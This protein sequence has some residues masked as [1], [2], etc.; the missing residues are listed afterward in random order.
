M[1]KKGYIILISIIIF[2]ILLGIGIFGIE[3]YKE[4]KLKNH[5]IEK[6]GFE[7]SYPDTYKDIST[8]EDNKSE[9]LEGISQTVS[10][11]KYSEYYQSLNLVETVKKLKNE[12][13]RIKLQIEAI[14]IE[15]TA[16]QLEEI[17]NRYITMFKVYNEEKVIQ[18]QN[19][20]IIKINDVDA[21]K[22]TLKIK[23]EDS[24]A[25]MTTYLISTEEKEITITFI[26]SEE[27]MT[28]NEK[29]INKI[30]NSLKI[31]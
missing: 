23:G 21:G 15:K 14:K 16:L 8:S 31:Y 9:I 28:K 2:G 3:K 17:C 18:S 30:I 25:V 5:I 20:E 1:K 26:G 27:Q 6:Y 11:E 22:V 12:K 13:S 7:I 4:N 24:N 10:G 29:Q 19:S